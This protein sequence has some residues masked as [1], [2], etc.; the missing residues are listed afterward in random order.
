MN[1]LDVLVQKNL[2]EKKDISEIEKEMKSSGL[3]V[4]EILVKRGIKPEDILI[5]VCRG[6]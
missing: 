3:S 1:I 6:H 2:L 4:E 5:T